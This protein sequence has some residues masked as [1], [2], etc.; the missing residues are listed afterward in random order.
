MIAASNVRQVTAVAQ[1]LA[2]AAFMF[3][4]AA[5][6]LLNMAVPIRNH[7]ASA[8]CEHEVPEASEVIQ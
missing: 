4:P 7:P 5:Y 3:G 1:P 8:N 2:R 6:Y